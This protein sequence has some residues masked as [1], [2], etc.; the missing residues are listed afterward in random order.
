MAS[1][2]GL[3]RP[4]SLNLPPPDVGFAT[5]SASAA[6][7]QQLPPPPPAQWQTSDEAMHYWLRAK[8]E[9]DRRKQEEEKTRQET[10][11]LEQRKV[12]QSML[13]DSLQAGIPPHIIPFIFA[14]ICQGGLSQPVL[15]LAQQYLSQL[16]GA[17][18][19]N[20]HI[21]PPSHSHTSSQSTSQSQR[22]SPHVRQDSRSGHPTSYAP[23]P[24]QHVVPPPPPPNILLSQNLPP[25]SSTPSTPQPLGGHSLAT[26]PPDS[27]IGINS[28][29]NPSYP[30]QAQ[31]APVNLGNVQYA[32][33]SSVP[34][35]QAARGSDSQSRRSPPSLS[36]HHWV[37]PT[38]AHSAATPSNPRRSEQSSPGRKRKASGSHQPAPVPPS[39]PV[40]SSFSAFQTSGPGSPRSDGRQGRQ[41]G[42]RHQLSDPPPYHSRGQLKPEETESSSHSLGA[43]GATAPHRRTAS[44]ETRHNLA[45]HAHRGDVSSVSR[46]EKLR[47]LEPPYSSKLRDSDPEVS[48]RHSPASGNPLA[49]TQQSGR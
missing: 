19:P 26:G 43:P 18:T 3:P 7:D 48:P 22:P 38:Q 30:T 40:E 27:R 8:A 31:S 44:L 32:P 14:G 17:R 45:D 29:G 5:M 33:G 21:S 1:R 25:N 42:H 24:A 36:F 4:S 11:R 13:R 41:F 39:R 6:P 49:S 47:A 10:L 34:T 20:H 37:P 2:G 23:P 46:I 9:E 16:P 28:W 35:T 15:E 12:E